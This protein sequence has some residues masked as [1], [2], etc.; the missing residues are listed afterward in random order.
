M[1]SV[2]P[3][4]SSNGFT[5]MRLEYLRKIPDRTF[6]FPSDHQFYLDKMTALFYG[7]HKQP[8]FESSLVTTEDFAKRF[9]RVG[10]K[11]LRTTPI[12]QSEDKSILRQG[13]LVVIMDQSEL[14]GTVGIAVDYVG[15]SREYSHRES[16]KPYYTV[17]VKTGEDTEGRRTGWVVCL[18]RSQF[19]TIDLK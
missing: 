14:N 6:Q 1:S 19:R 4:Q 12:D 11:L 5:G 17:L 8:L 7:A 15:M 9:S 2:S 18:D 3:S 16:P 10:T 13:D